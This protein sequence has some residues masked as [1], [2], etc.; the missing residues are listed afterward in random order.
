MLSIERKFISEQ[1]F[2]NTNPNQNTVRLSTE[3]LSVFTEF[4]ATAGWQVAY[5][6]TGKGSFEG[7]FD[8]CTQ[9]DVVITRRFT[10]R[11]WIGRGTSPENCIS[12]LIP[13]AGGEDCVFQGRTLGDTDLFMMSPGSEGS[14]VVSDN[15]YLL[16]INIPK[17]RLR[18]L[19]QLNQNS[20]SQPIDRLVGE[21]RVI[22]FPERAYLDLIHAVKQIHLHSRRKNPV[23]ASPTVLGELEESLIAGLCIG[24]D[25]QLAIDPG[26]RVRQNHV[27]HYHRAL[28]YIHAHL[29][30]PLGWETLC[31]QV[32][33]SRRTLEYAFRSVSGVTPGQYIKLR[34]LAA[35]RKMLAEADPAQTTV[36]N[37]ALEYAFHHLGYFALDYKSLYGESPSQTLQ[38]QKKPTFL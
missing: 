13:I 28:D 33:V 10:N 2:M 16:G 31:H 3:D 5:Q 6:Q 36:T 35:A 21:T 15:S 20:L 37:I 18:S 14:L 4:S 26:A 38:S 30:E 29:T 22:R 9:N 27:R 25:D 24:F 11:A 32:G 12:F 8:I 7:W 17:D 1:Q 23:G 34:R 19:T